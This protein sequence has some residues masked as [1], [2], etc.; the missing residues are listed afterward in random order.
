MKDDSN[1]KKKFWEKQT[2]RKLMLSGVKTIEKYF[3]SEAI[4]K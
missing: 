4:T 1:V 2:S 3:T